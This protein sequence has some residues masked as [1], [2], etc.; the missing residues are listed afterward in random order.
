MSNDTFIERIGDASEFNGALVEMLGPAPCP[1]P[2]CA[3][4]GE[5]VRIGRVVQLTP[6]PPCSTEIEL[7]WE[8]DE[9]AERARELLKLAGLT[10]RFDDW[11]LATYPD[12]E[13]GRAAR[14]VAEDWIE[15]W[16]RGDPANLLLFGPVGSGKTGLAWSIVRCVIE[17]WLVRARLVV[18]HELLDEMRTAMR[19][20]QPLDHVTN[21]A[22]VPVL[23]LDDLGAERPTPFACAELLALIDLRWRRKLPTIITSNYEPDVLAERL[24]HDDPVIGERIVSRMSDGAVQHR[25]RANDRRI[26]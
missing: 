14:K 26:S 9:H 2:G 22:R 1:M 15:R 5:R 20:K 16:D 24:G 21:L 18:F 25:L 12:D 17:R 7:Q 4:T 11:S 10:P 13:G 23:A 8:K 3:R 19:T 6:C